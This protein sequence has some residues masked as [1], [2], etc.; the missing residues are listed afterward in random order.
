MH[1]TEL[2][3]RQR[4]TTRV[5]VYLSCIVES[6]V[7]PQLQVTMECML[8]YVTHSLVCA[9]HPPVFRQKTYPR[10]N[11]WEDKLT[12]SSRLKTM[13]THIHIQNACTHTKHHVYLQA[14]THIYSLCIPSSTHI[15][16]HMQGVQWKE[17]WRVSR[18]GRKGY[19]SM[20]WGRLLL[21]LRWAEILTVPVN[22]VAI[23]NIRATLQCSCRLTF[24]SE[25]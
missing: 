24:Y 1:C 21:S 4:R 13:Q 19:G 7:I 22:T 18:F 16:T 2:R 5:S 25:V 6:C 20:G 23:A 8:L 17:L 15:L 3:W 12:K 11:W 10:E 9:V 14:H